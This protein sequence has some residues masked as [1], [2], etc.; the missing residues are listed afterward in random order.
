MSEKQTDSQPESMTDRQREID[1]CGM[2][3]RMLEILMGMKNV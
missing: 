1:T 3:I 2:L